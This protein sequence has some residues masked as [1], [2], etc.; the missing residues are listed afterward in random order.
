[1]FEERLVLEDGVLYELV[2]RS[3]ADYHL[4]CSKE[5]R[6]LVEYGSTGGY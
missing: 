4:A 5:G 3:P 2:F 1:M 6:V